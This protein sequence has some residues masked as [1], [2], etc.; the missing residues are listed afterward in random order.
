MSMLSDKQLH[1][2]IFHVSAIL[3]FHRGKLEKRTVG[4]SWIAQIGYKEC[5]IPSRMQRGDVLQPRIVA[6]CPASSHN[7]TTATRAASG[8]FRN[9][10]HDP[11]APESCRECDPTEA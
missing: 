9:S 4:F 5:H 1:K 2:A 3:P 8:Q 6:E 7:S 10:I 11:Q